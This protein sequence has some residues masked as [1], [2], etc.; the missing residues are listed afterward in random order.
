MRATDDKASANSA[1]EA[2]R[3]QDHRDTCGTAP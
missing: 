2:I 1:L 3:R